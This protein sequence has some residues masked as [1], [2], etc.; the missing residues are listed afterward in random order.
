MMTEL[1]NIAYTKRVK[2]LADIKI[3]YLQLPEE[4][5]ETVYETAE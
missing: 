1:E 5:P 4:L 3:N 2:G